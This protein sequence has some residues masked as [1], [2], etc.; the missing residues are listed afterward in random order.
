MSN[1]YNPYGYPTY[2]VP[3]PVQQE[4]V[5][6]GTECDNCGGLI[7]MGQEA[8]EIFMGVLGRG[9]KSGQPMVVESLV[10]KD[11]PVAK[12]HPECC[13]EFI[14]HFVCEMEY[15]EPLCSV[16]ESKLEGD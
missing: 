12:L 3:Q 14:N 2:Y 4:T 15:E 7:E 13:V 16:C 6:E 10:N 11:C 5:V 8:V 9:K 1:P